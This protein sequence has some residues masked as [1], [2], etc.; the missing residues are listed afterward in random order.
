MNCSSVSGA[1]MAGAAEGCTTG[2]S[3]LPLKVERRRLNMDRLPL[4][5]DLKYPMLLRGGAEQRDELAPP[6]ACSH[7]EGLYPTTPLG[8]CRVVRHRKFCGQCLSWVIF[9]Q[10]TGGCKPIHVRSSPNSDS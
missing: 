3:F 4:S 7:Q 5:A 6:H 10:D 2:A 8:K 1:G 9:D